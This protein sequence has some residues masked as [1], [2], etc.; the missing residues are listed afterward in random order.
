MKISFFDFDGWILQMLYY[1]RIDSSEGIDPDK[2]K[3]IKECI[4][5]RY[6]FFNR[7]TNSMN[8]SNERKINHMGFH[9]A[10]LDS[11]HPFYNENRRFCEILF[12][13]NFT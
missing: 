7:S 1:N 8:Q 12:V 13:A 6:W 5:C 4:I 3:N 9:F 2:S 10:L 11:T